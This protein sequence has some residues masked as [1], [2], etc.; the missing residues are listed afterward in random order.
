MI[1]QF[2]DSAAW[3]VIGW[4]LLHYVWVGAALG[5]AAW[6]LRRVVGRLSP[7]LRYAAALGMLVLLAVAPG[8]I[9]W[10]IV[11]RRQ[12]AVALA[13][14]LPAPMPTEH[15]AAM[16]AMLSEPPRGAA[17]LPPM[18]TRLPPVAP[19]S[20]EA[21]VT[22]TA[23]EFLATA[24]RW[25]PAAWLL[26]MP[27]TLGLL[28]T[29][30]AGASRLRRGATLL[31]EGPV[32][33]TTVR[34]SEALR[35]ARRVAVGVSE[36]VVAPMA[37]GILRPTI[38]LPAAVLAGHTPAQLEMILLHELAHIRRADNLI[39]VLQ[40]VCEAVLFFQPAVWIVSRWVRLEREHCCD[41]TV[42]GY[43]GDPQGYA[44][45]LA[46]LAIP[47][48]S[49]AY[50]AA[51]M[52]NHQLVTR[53]QN[54][55]NV[56]EQTM[57]LSPKLAAFVG[58]LMLVLGLSLATAQ[59]ARNE[60]TATKQ[61]DA[62]I[63]ASK[64]HD[65]TN[66]MASGVGAANDAESLKAMATFFDGIH[67]RP[68]GTTVEG[69]NAAT[70]SMAAMLA[71]MTAAGKAARRGW[72]AEQATGAPDVT[73]AGDSESAWASLTPD[74]QDEWLELDYA[75][76]VP[77]VAVMIVCNQSPG[78][79]AKVTVFDAKNPGLAY[80]WAGE[81]SGKRDGD[82]AVSVFSLPVS[83]TT[84]KV[85]V[86]VAST[87]VVGW[88]EIDAVGLIDA[89]GKTHWASGATASST[90]A[91]RDASRQTASQFDNA[92]RGSFDAADGAM[93]TN[94]LN[95]DATK[96]VAR[97]WGPEQATGAPN[98]NGEGD[99]PHAWAS[100]T[101]DGAREELTLEYSKAVETV[102]VL[103][104]QSCNPGAVNEIRAA[105]SQQRSAPILG[106]TAVAALFQKT[107]VETGPWQTV[108]E[109]RHADGA[110]LKASPM[111]VVLKAPMAI[112]H[113]N[114]V[115]DSPAVAGWN[116]I[117]AVGLLDAKGALH[118][119]TAATASSTYAEIVAPSGY[120][121]LRAA[122]LDMTAATGGDPS[123]RPSADLVKLQNQQSELEQQAAAATARWQH[124]QSKLADFKRRPVMDTMIDEALENDPVYLEMTQ[125]TIQLERAYELQKAAGANDSLNRLAQSYAQAQAQ[126]KD[127][128]QRAAEKVR[129]QI[130]EP[131]ETDLRSARREADMLAQQAAAMK[132]KVE[133][134]MADSRNTKAKSKNEAPETAHEHWMKAMQAV[135]DRANIDP[136]VARAKADL[137]KRAAQLQAE[138]AIYERTIEEMRREVQAAEALNKRA[139]ATAQEKTALEK[140]AGEKL[141]V[142]RAIEFLKSHPEAESVDRKVLEQWIEEKA[143][144]PNVAADKAKNAAGQDD[145]A[146][147]KQGEKRAAEAAAMKAKADADL[148]AAETAL[149]QGRA[150][151]AAKRLDAA[152]AQSAAGQP[153]LSGEIKMIAPVGQWATVKL[154][155]VR[156]VA[157]RIE[158]RSAAIVKI[159]GDGALEVQCQQASDAE[160]IGDDAKG[161]R[162]RVKVKFVVDPPK[163]DDTEK[164]K[165]KADAA[166]KRF[167]P[168]PEAKEEALAANDK[169]ALA[170]LELFGPAFRIMVGRDP[171][172]DEVLAFAG[173]NY[174]VR[175]FAKIVESKQPQDQAD[176]AL[177][178][179]SNYR[180][181]MLLKYLESVA[182]KNAA[183][184]QWQSV[185]TPGKESAAEIGRSR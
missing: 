85:R 154:P 146:A 108:F 38:L 160:L 14:N 157:V 167:H 10:Q 120:D 93:R 132:T 63:A 158:G 81:D 15:G 124:A 130:E 151:Q 180:L 134:A 140:Q 115:L 41:A 84:T 162:Y 114:L 2:V 30:L 122:T 127:Y 121:G 54:I 21:F 123:A 149:Q 138:R 25:A 165:A 47:G 129:K 34:W 58:G 159:D 147:I 50:A 12:P 16:A 144:D 110:N 70:G 52:A 17:A 53:I 43:T 44:E 156:F 148:H 145:N 72:G 184:R 40:R 83:M 150:E 22:R 28:A 102:A 80:T 92:V 60:E 103:V 137:E 169:A 166:R 91:D 39:N 142:D 153:K 161:N 107:T 42:L 178:G 51:A 64:Q 55:L 143:S 171:S 112:D 155:Q 20:T 131:A 172:Y 78:A 174:D 182:D 48:V 49:P 118:W 100:K 13:I 101:P 105:A 79:I 37:V 111:V 139:E 35:I 74:G 3:D 97:N 173:S 71:Y 176:A 152:A 27:L 95:A 94:R 8:V 117:D 11:E 82:R 128:R 62:E 46:S 66:R 116:E 29:G 77:A 24:V 19:E 136:D 90:Y 76:A 99:D 141:A 104:Y 185:L 87:K 163:A 61:A 4:T 75:D 69:Q 65:S 67:E 31:V 5:A 18:A 6:V 179:G 164:E 98:V 45:T 7:T 32:W 113:L 9:A 177:F 23:R 96:S 119:A 88:N 26:G 135:Q 73:A 183:A 68:G 126:L 125:R 33:E 89:S 56:Q 106:K 175:A 86:D 1:Q 36:R 109:S 133:K 57:S 181:Q 170:S 59:D 168:A